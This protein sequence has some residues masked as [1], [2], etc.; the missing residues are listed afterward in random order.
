[1]NAERTTD[2]EM[3]HILELSSLSRSTSLMPGDAALRSLSTS[4]IS[5][6]E[7]D[8]SLFRYHDISPQS[9]A[10]LSEELFAIR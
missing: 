8:L 5:H 10:F 4:I 6:K 7:F 2:E 1:M 3:D 9:C